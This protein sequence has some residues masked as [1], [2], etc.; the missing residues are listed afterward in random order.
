MSGNDALLDWRYRLSGE[1]AHAAGQISRVDS[2]LV[3]FI[4]IWKVTL[5]ELNVSYY[6][7][8]KRYIQWYALEW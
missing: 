3:D 4:A 2:T 6:M 1:G 7:Y 5:Y 8:I